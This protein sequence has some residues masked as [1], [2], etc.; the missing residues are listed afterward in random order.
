MVNIRAGVVRDSFVAAVIVGGALVLGL[1]A[2]QPS[3][4]DPDVGP[5]VA[6]LAILLVVSELRPM[7]WHP[8]A[9][10]FTAS[11]GFAGAIA[12]LAPA[13]VA[14]AA[15]AVASLAGDVVTRKSPVRAAFNAG[16]LVLSLGAGIGVL[17]LLGAR[18]SLVDGGHL[19]AWF[20]P[21]TLAFAGSVF[22]VNL[23]LM[24]AVVWLDRGLD[25]GQ[26]VRNVLPQ[27]AVDDLL[28]LVMAPVLA[29]IG[30][31]SMA[32]LP[33]PLL[34][35]VAMH[36][37]AHQASTSR[38]RASRDALTGLANR[39]E[40][41]EALAAAIPGGVTVAM[42]D[43]DEFKGV[44]DRLGHAAGDKV[45]GIVAKR[46][47]AAVRP[48]DL[49]G[50]IGGDEFVVVLEGAVGHDARV[51]I[52]RIQRQFRQPI[53]IDG[54][55]VPVRASLGAAS[56]PMDGIDPGTLLE[57]AD[58]ALLL[59]KMHTRVAGDGRGRTVDT[60]TSSLTLL[61]SLKEAL[62]ASELSV[63]FQ[64]QVAMP[65][66]ETVGFEALVRWER[67]GVTVL[68]ADFVYAAE[69]TELIGE[70]TDFVLD[71]S[72][73]TCARW[74]HDDQQVRVSVNVSARSLADVR[75]V[76]TVRVSARAV[77][78]ARPGARGR[79]HRER[80]AGRPRR[81]PGHARGSAPTW[82]WP[83]PSTTS[84]P[85]TRRSSTCAGCPSPG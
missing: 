19:S 62:A 50:R 66:G 77:R 44:N 4:L 40:I 20:L 51:S 12:L 3:T 23:S 35:I 80:P 65:G 9:G 47:L 34:C 27:T 71:E 49:V 73:A 7:Q 64:P 5:L 85:A 28:L 56:A 74:W 53:E 17:Q 60:V 72:L 70:L 22:L 30:L 11:W 68:P 75:F 84:A 39:T 69:H 21:Q 55:P 25:V 10:E 67:D 78:P 79:V 59:E 1:V 31:Q 8:R 61:R 33:L 43:L 76:D 48:V 37:T 16:T 82:A 58:A 45:L 2:R 52:E 36:R 13:E 81:R 29:I 32:L 42:I 18:T 38:V 6:V 26:I 14:L 41:L 57:R 83:W 24:A 54:V 46:L 63:V 15:V